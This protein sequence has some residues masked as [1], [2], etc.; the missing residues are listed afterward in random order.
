MKHTRDE[1]YT[2]ILK[3]GKT[4]PAYLPPHFLQVLPARFSNFLEIWSWNQAFCP[5]QLKTPE[6]G[7][8]G[9]GPPGHATAQ[10]PAASSLP[11]SG[12]AGTHRAL[13]DNHC[14]HGTPG[15]LRLLLPARLC[16]SVPGQMLFS[17]SS[18]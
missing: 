12:I 4:Q 17:A 13:R 8:P 14:P 5:V 15:P 6:R 2:G 7:C 11:P 18:T 9:P 10:P 16:P 3:T 1:Y